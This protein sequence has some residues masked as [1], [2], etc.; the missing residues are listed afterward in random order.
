[1]HY[2]PGLVGKLA[3]YGCRQMLVHPFY[4]FLGL[5]QLMLGLL[6]VC[7]SSIHPLLTELVE[8]LGMCCFCCC[9]R[10]LRHNCCQP[11]HLSL[12][13][14]RYDTPAPAAGVQGI[15][16]HYLLYVWVNEKPGKQLLQSGAAMGKRVVYCIMLA[17]LSIKAMV[18]LLLCNTGSRSTTIDTSQ[19]QGGKAENHAALVVFLLHAEQQ[20]E[21]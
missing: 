3:I 19:K 20:R 2:S 4:I 14:P 5:R 8:Q 10:E 15:A 9:L 11:I 13:E 18:N 16:Q 6:Q 1:M 7:Q 21:P 17:M 12:H